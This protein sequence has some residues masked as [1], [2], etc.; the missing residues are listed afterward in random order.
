MSTHS[1]TKNNLYEYLTGELPPPEHERVEDHLTKCSRCSA[2]AE[3]IRAALAAIPSWKAGSPADERPDEF[4]SSFAER[5]LAS[6]PPPKPSFW[7]VCR[8]T[9]FSALSMRTAI[10]ATVGAAAVLAA[11]L[12]S[13]RP[14][15]MQRPTTEAPQGPAVVPA[16]DRMSD[17]F[18]KSKMLLVGISNMKT[19]GNAPI[20]VSAERRVSQKLLTEARYLQ[21]TPIDPRSARLIGDL[22]KILIQLS[23]LKD[24]GSAENV[25]IIRGG[26]HQENLLFKIRIAE[27]V[28]DSSRP[29]VPNYPE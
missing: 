7:A 22:E 6:S 4:W 14:R 11:V 27:S 2:D 19:E 12:V 16:N 18:R 20:D 17:Y 15:D 10:T 24:E 28:L 9:L 1:D 5:V 23:N 3:K 25:E 13:E 26:I 29:D 21:T 8:E